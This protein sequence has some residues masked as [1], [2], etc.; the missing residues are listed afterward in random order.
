MDGAVT[1]YFETCDEAGNPV[2]LVERATVHRSGLWH[3]AVHVWV[4]RSDGRI[5]VQRR[6]RNK[7]VSP[8]CWDVTVGE[9]LQ[10]GEDYLDAA[11]RGLLEELGLSGIEPVAVT[12]ERR[13]CN[14]RPD[15]GILDREIQ[16][17]YRAVH[18]GPVYPEPE[19]IAALEL[20]TPAHL[21][22]RVEQDP[23]AFTPGLKADLPHLPA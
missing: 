1:E 22:A 18:D 14:E 16:R 23:E 10:P 20:W 12:G 9:H 15:L 13:I 4:F 19:E 21:R 2:G 3:R 5:H 17:M 8:G 6:S 11:R 7:D